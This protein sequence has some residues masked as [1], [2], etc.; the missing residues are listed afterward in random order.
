MKDLSDIRE[1]QGAAETVLHALK[2]SGSTG[3]HVSMFSN[4]ISRLSVPAEQL[5]AVSALCGLSHVKDLGDIYLESV[6]GFDWP[7]M[8]GHLHGVC[9]I[10]LEKN[11]PDTLIGR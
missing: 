7:N 4:E 5:A 6:P 8:V 2:R 1:I 9:T 3:V 11:D 10:Y